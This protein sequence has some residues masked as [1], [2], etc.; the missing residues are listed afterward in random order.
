MEPGVS[1]D[2]STAEPSSSSGHDT[3]TSDSDTY[4]QEEDDEPCSEEEDLLAE[5]EA[6]LRAYLAAPPVT[7]VFHKK[8]G[9]RAGKCIEPCATATDT[10][11]H[12][13]R[14]SRT[15]VSTSRFVAEPAR[16][17]RSRWPPPAA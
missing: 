13:G 7:E 12:S 10:E 9:R 1:S 11:V 15:R 3:P 2:S 6:A 8:R 5:K 4:L 16:C 17:H 14:P